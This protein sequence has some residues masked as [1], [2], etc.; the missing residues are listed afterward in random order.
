VF[1]RGLVVPAAALPLTS[2]GPMADVRPGA[3][4]GKVPAQPIDAC[5]HVTIGA[6]ADGYAGER[7][8][9]PPGTPAGFTD[10]NGEGCLGH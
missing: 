4:A 1:L 5:P 9:R 6:D 2:G 7:D 8:V 3:A 10:Q